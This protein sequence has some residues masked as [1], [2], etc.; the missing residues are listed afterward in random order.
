[1]LTF[2]RSIPMLAAIGG[3]LWFVIEA[4]P[5]FWQI[6]TFAVGSELL[7]FGEKLAR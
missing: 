4:P 2:I 7:L 1:M 5:E 3:G 6:A